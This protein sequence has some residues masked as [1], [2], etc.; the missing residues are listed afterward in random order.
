MKK[1]ELDQLISLLEA[2]VKT[3]L[4]N[5]F[6]LHGWGRLLRAIYGNIPLWFTSLTPREQR[7]L[8]MRFGLELGITHTLDETAKKLG[9]TR[10]RIRQIE[11]KALERIR[12]QID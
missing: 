12:T 10:V 9:T 6:I 4:L 1:V 8:Q 2:G 7:V 3:T 11:A 5:H